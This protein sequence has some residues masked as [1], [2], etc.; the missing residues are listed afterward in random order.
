M[1]FLEISALSL[2]VTNTGLTIA[3]VL[4]LVAKRRSTT[5]FTVSHAAFPGALFLLTL[6]ITSL[7][8]GSPDLA[9]NVTETA[10]YTAAAGFGAATL[11][12]S[13]RFSTGTAGK[14]TAAGRVCELLGYVLPVA[15]A[16]TYALSVAAAAVG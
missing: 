8:A 7:L 1:T 13:S 6:V 2:L 14:P 12:W 4:M 5:P 15:S 16:V 10:V 9:F 11:V 3:L